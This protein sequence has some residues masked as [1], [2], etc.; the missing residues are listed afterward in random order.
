MA[1]TL[2]SLRLSQVRFHGGGGI[3]NE[4]SDAEKLSVENQDTILQ[5]LR[6]AGQA[7]FQ[8]PYLIIKWERKVPFAQSTVCVDGSRLLKKPR[9]KPNH[10]HKYQEN[11][12][13]FFYIIIFCAA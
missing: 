9:N 5:V 7:R 12:R 8:I 3:H 11:I 2:C 4:M 10:M 1:A 13:L 6:M